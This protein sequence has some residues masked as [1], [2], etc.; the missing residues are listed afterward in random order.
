MDNEAAKKAIFR[1]I[2]EAKEKDPGT[3]PWVAIL[4]FSQG[5]KIAASLLYD[6]QVREEKK[7]GRG[8]PGFKFGVLIAGRGPLVN[9]SDFGWNEFFVQP[10]EQVESIQFD[11]VSN[12]QLR[13]PTIHVQGLQDPD[14]QWQLKFIKQYCD[15]RS[16]KLFVWDGDHRVP[17]K[18]EDVMPVVNDVYRIARDQGV[19]VRQY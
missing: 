2:Q 9:L 3:G 17:Y 12:H 10:G 11:G 16:A 18:D 8:E 4:G 13:I 6:Q 19:Y 15:P 14:I 1:S 5:A 7:G